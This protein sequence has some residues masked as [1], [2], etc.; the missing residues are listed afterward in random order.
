MYSGGLCAIF[1][2]LMLSNKRFDITDGKAI[3]NPTG[4]CRKAACR[5]KRKYLTLDPNS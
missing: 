1:I 2:L 3:E 4:I 5:G